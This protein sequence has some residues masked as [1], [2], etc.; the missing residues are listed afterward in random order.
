MITGFFIQIFLA[1]VGFFI[2]VL[3]IYALPSGISSAFTLI[4]GYVNALSFLFPVGTLLTVVGIAIFF[5]ISMFAMDAILYI[6][7]LIRGR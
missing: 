5:H 1:L 4:M 2:G 3:P 6:I 7:H